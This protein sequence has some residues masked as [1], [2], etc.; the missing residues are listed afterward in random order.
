MFCPQCGS[1]NDDLNTTCSQC[2]AALPPAA[3]KLGADF[4]LALEPL[5]EPPPAAAAEPEPTAFA[6]QRPASAP[7]RSGP[8]ASAAQRSTR[9]AYTPPAPSNYLVQAILVTLCCCLPFGIAS[10]VY[11][12]QVNGKYAA[13][14]VEGAYESARKAKMWFWWGL[15]IGLIV[16]VLAVLVQIAAVAAGAADF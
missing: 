10:I 11:A 16:N 12:A 2:H 5:P 7:Q 3:A 15:G 6:A 9:A 13:G 14:D 4:E 1:H 8:A